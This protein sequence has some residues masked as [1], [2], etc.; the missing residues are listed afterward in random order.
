[1]NEKGYYITQN[2]NIPL[3]DREPGEI[4]EVA[5]EQLKPYRDIARTWQTYTDGY[6]NRCYACHQNIWFTTDPKR[7]PY[8]YS[9]DELMALITAHI[10][11]C[12]EEVASDRF[13]A[14]NG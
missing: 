10:R 12:H 14:E 11:Q 3:N 13:P 9:E 1:M 2:K 5:I 8:Q 6:T 4:A 7:R